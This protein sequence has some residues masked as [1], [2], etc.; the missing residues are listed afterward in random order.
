MTDSDVPDRLDR[1]AST[2]AVRSGVRFGIAAT[3]AERMATFGLRHAAIAEHGWRPDTGEQTERDL[4][5][6]RAVHVIGRRDG[7]LI[8]SGRLV[9]PPGPLPTE[10]ACGIRVR[11]AG[12]VVDVG[13]MVVAPQARGPDRTVFLALLAALYLRTRRLGFATGCGMMT[14]TTRVLLAHL[15]I[16]LEL[17]GEDRP[18][19][20]VDRAPVRFDVGLHGDTVLARWV[21]AQV[22]GP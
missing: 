15:G 17:L 4:F 1:L 7:E 6:E 8:C 16:A 12:R 9:L 18:Y 19:W 2:L 20:G 10:E 13:R 3:D 21:D 5:D 14:P 22:A 11:P